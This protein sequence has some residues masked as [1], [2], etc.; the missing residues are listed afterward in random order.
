MK[1]RLRPILM[2]ADSGCSRFIQ[3]LIENIFTQSTDQLLQVVDTISSSAPRLQFPRSSRLMGG[4]VCY[5]RV[6]PRT[7]RLE[8]FFIDELT[9]TG[10]AGPG[11]KSDASVHWEIRLRGL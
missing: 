5:S 8:K 2:P 6:R 4:I 9:P 3:P 11:S 7:H 1:E 10:E